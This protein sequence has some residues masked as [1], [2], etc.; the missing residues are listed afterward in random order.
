MGTK[1]VSQAGAPLPLGEAGRSLLLRR[2]L[3][4]F[5][6]GLFG[7]RFLRSSH[8]GLLGNRVVVIAQ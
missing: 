4:G 2:L 5:F 6:G 8:G 1:S 7:R 3:S